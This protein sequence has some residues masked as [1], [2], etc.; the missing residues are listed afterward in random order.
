MEIN[1]FALAVMAW[2]PVS[3]K[4]RFLKFQSAQQFPVRHV[5]RC[6]LL[7]RLI[8]CC[9]ENHDENLFFW[10]GDRLHK[11]P[12]CLCKNFD[13]K[14]LTTGCRNKSYKSFILT[15]A[16]QRNQQIG[17]E[18]ANDEF[19]ASDNL[20]GYSFEPQCTIKHCKGPSRIICCT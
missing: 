5:A 7:T 1:V 12:S 15:R 2:T 4:L 17:Y 3:I 19:A 8:Q 13:F 6:C 20:I 14:N 18:E 11:F 9:L 10:G 16:L